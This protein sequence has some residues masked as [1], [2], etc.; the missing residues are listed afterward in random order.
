MDCTFVTTFADEVRMLSI[1]S[2]ES[3]VE[4]S[5]APRK[6][7]RYLCRKNSTTRNSMHM[8][9]ES[10]SHRSILTDEWLAQSIVRSH[11]DQHN[12]YKGWKPKRT[13][14]RS[15]NIHKYICIYIYI[16]IFWEQYIYIYIYIYIIVSLNNKGNS[17]NSSP[18]TIGF[19]T[20]IET[21]QFQT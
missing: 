8:T 21:H 4:P 1:T 15:C 7:Q 6:K 18:Y 10:Q 2:V 20:Y 12:N 17:N 9:A 14:G 16:Y 13:N 5:L 11:V 19:D 3:K